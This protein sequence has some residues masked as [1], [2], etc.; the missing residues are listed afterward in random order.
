MIIVLIGLVAKTIGY[1]YTQCWGKKEV[2]S[3]AQ[4]SCCEAKKKKCCCTSNSKLSFDKDSLIN[5]ALELDIILS[6][7]WVDFN[8]YFN[9]CFRKCVY[10]IIL[11]NLSFNQYYS[12]PLFLLH[13]RFNI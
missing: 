5:H 11:K 10:N 7:S 4:K 6:F 3:I 8:N 9:F 13:Q 1:G 2:C 12:P